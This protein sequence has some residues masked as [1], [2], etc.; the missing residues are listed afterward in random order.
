M[1]K[2]LRKKPKIRKARRADFDAI[3]RI[4]QSHS[5]DPWSAIAALRWW[6]QQGTHISLAFLDEKLV[7]YVFYEDEPVHVQLH[8]L[9]VLPEYRRQGVA[10]EL[11]RVVLKHASKLQKDSVQI[12]VAETDLPAQLFLR[13]QGYRGSCLGDHPDRYLFRQVVSPA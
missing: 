9:L 7:G 11:S 6:K 4:E 10:A 12:A 5:R 3:A 2:T 13:S 1:G 8:H